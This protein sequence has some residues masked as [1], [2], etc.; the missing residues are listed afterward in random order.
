MPLL[1]YVI[2]VVLRN[3]V[4][5]AMVMVEKRNSFSSLLHLYKSIPLTSL[6]ANFLLNRPSYIYIYW[7]CSMFALQASQSNL[8]TE[9]S[10]VEKR[11]SSSNSSPTPLDNLLDVLHAHNNFIQ[12][13]NN[14]FP[15]E[16]PHA[17]PHQEE[18]ENFHSTG[19]ENAWISISRGCFGRSCKFNLSKF[20]EMT[21]AR[22]LNA[23]VWSILRYA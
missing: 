23:A 18:R 17:S 16:K 20:E 21:T 10:H 13:V 8:I 19:N 7:I 2:I 22:P 5:V 1:K 6:Y 3:C 15:L 4:F 11:F 14:S 12:K 9:E